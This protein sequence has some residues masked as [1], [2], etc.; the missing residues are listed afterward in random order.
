MNTTNSNKIAMA[1]L[2]TCLSVMALGLVADGIYGHDKLEA[3][4]YALPGGEAG[5]GAGKEAAP[6]AAAEPLPVLLA[7][8]DV[9][10]GEAGAKTCAACHSFDKGGAVKVGPPLY[11]VVGRPIAS[12][13]G[14]AYSEAAK[15]KGGSWSL[16][17]INAFITAPKAY[18][19]GTKMAYP[20]QPDAAKRADILDYLNTLSDSPAPLPK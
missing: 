10:R 20:G 3:A 4:G 14:F 11:G 9:G 16:E 19:N 6:A 1:V 12:V 8:A 15:G 17:A 2:G 7:K 18:I 13:A 5:E